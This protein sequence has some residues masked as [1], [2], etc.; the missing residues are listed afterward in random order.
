M[1]NGYWVIDSENSQ[2][3]TSNIHVLHG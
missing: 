3:T 1:T 2:K